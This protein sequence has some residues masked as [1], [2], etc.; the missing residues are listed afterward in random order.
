MLDKTM[1]TPTPAGEDDHS[2][3]AF[4]MCQAQPEEDEKEEEEMDQQRVQEEEDEERGGHGHPQPTTAGT[5]TG[6]DANANTDISQQPGDGP[7]RPIRKIHP[8]R[9][10]AEIFQCCLV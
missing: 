1:D 3:P 10:M 9:L 4:S 6:H 5:D 2:G 8:S 7:R